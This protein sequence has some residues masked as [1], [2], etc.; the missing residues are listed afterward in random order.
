M[1]QKYCG[2]GEWFYNLFEEWNILQ[3]TEALKKVTCK[4]WYTGYEGQSNI[5]TAVIWSVILPYEYQL[6]QWFGNK[7]E[8]VTTD[9]KLISV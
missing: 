7:L 4:N 3:K 9:I 8:I 1:D 5:K 6:P 2:W